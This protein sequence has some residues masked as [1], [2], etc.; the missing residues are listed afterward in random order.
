MNA[1]NSS[2]VTTQGRLR[3][4]QI[5]GSIMSA[6]LMIA[7]AFGILVLIVLLISIVR[8]GG[9]TLNWNFMTALPSRFPDRAG[10]RVALLGSIW[11]MV[12]TAFVT[13]PIGVGAAI[14]LEEFAPPGRITTTIRTNI[15]NLAGVPSIVYGLLGLGIFVELLSMGRSIAAGA[16]T[17]S[18]LVL[19]VVII[20][21]QEAL[22]AVPDSIRQGGL[23]LGATRLQVVRAHVF[24]A[25]LPGILTG[26]ILALSR[27][28]GET[29][30]LIVIGAVAFLNFSPEG[31]GSKFSVLPLAIYGWTARPQDDF[32]AIAAG[33]IIVLLAV[34]LT[35]NMGAILLRNHFQNKQ[36]G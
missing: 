6:A 23:A 20:A 21:S 36:Q 12:L 32:H 34:L 1:I 2:L 16:L 24:P 8:D 19:P 27:A 35:M 18:L 7:T 9:H 11:I 29:A 5:F 13:F 22:R 25:A 28:I 3:R 17:L 33:G 30:P 14:Y 31:L 15:A 26:T 4:R 10:I